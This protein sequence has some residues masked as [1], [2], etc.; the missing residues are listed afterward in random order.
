MANHHDDVRFEPTDV[1]TG[2]VVWFLA[3]L[4]VSLA[5]VMLVLWWT[6]VFELRTHHVADQAV[7]KQ[8]T[9][10]PEPRI[11]G[12]GMNQASHSV[13]NA[14]IA[15]SARTLRNEENKK[16]ADGWIDAAGKKHPPIEQAMKMLIEQLKNKGGQR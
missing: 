13:T 16:L 3:I 14:D 5:I 8:M 12:V 2:P 11:E 1:R 7:P 9:F 4:G 15:T 6:Q 10:P